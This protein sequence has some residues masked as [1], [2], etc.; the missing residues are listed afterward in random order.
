MPANLVL[1]ALQH[2][3][4][5]L[6]PF[7]HPMAVMGGLALATWQHLR[8]TRDVDVLI[9]VFSFRQPGW[10]PSR[11]SGG[12]ISAWLTGAVPQF[13]WIAESLVLACRPQVLLESDWRY[14]RQW[15]IVSVPRPS[16]SRVSAKL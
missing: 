15:G 8:A 6:E 2:V 12:P 10:W 1:G 3:W 11:R 13:R 14:A 5:T 9:V 16:S 4:R 7:D